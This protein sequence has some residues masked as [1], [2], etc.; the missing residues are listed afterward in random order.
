MTD[1][2]RWPD[3]FLVGAHKSA[4]TSVHRYLDQ[5]PEVSMLDKEGQSSYFLK[6]ARGETDL[7]EETYLE[8]VRS[9]G[10]GRLR[11]EA[12]VSL[13]YH[14]DAP[15]LIHAKAPDAKIVVSIRDPIQRA[16]SNY[17]RMVTAGREELDFTA[18]AKAEIEALEALADEDDLRAVH[19]AAARIEPEETSPDA[20]K[21][22]RIVDKSLLADRIERYVDRFGAGDVH[23]ILVADL[24]RDTEG[25]L[26]DLFSFL[27]VDPDAT[28]AID[29]DRHN[30]FHGIPYGGVVEAFRTSPTVKQ[31]AQTV[32]PEGVRDWLGNE[33]LL[34]Q[35]PS[36]P[37]VPDDARSMLAEFFE[38]DVRK[39]EEVLDRDL[40]EL[41]ASFP[42]GTANLQDPGGP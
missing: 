6:R 41:R 19:R 7:G 34:E 14:P 2:A 11:G 3:L 4:S 18:S 30:T 29:T 36:K 20:P 24:K 25:T 26:R 40:P 42:E 13:L 35:R 21:R 5:H 28:P 1:D 22:L 39:L 15:D 12:T 8:M 37:P 16:Y 31:I 10:D 23:A 33:V 38:P 27:G 17:W 32:L 9:A